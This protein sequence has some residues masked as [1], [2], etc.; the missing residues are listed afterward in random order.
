VV[1]YWDQRGTGKSSKADPNTID[2]ARLVS[3]VR[4]MV[5]ALCLRLKVDEVDIVGFSLGATLATMAAADRCRPQPHRL[6]DAGRPALDCA[7]RINWG[8]P[9]LIASH[10]AIRAPQSGVLCLAISIG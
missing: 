10:G 3:D 8:I 5:D 4:S 2:V 6:E 7:V 9:Q 1:A